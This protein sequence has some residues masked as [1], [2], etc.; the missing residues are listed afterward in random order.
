MRTRGISKA[1][2][3]FFLLSVSVVACVAAVAAQVPSG[4]LQ[5]GNKEFHVYTWG[6]LEEFSKLVDKTT[7]KAG[8]ISRV[9][10]KN[11]IACDT[12][13]GEVNPTN[14]KEPQWSKKWTPIPLNGIQFSGEGHTISGL[15][16]VDTVGLEGGL[17][18]A[19]YGNAV[20]KDLGIVNS[21][22]AGGSYAGAI[23]GGLS[24]NARI[25]NC[26]VNKTI[27]KASGFVG[28]IVGR[29]YGSGMIGCIYSAASVRGM[30]DDTK[31]GGL[32]GWIFDQAVIEDCFWQNTG[33]ESLPQIEFG[34]FT[35]SAFKISNCAGKTANAMRGYDL[36]WKLNEK[37]D[38][39]DYLWICSDT[40]DYP[41]LGD[42]T[43]LLLRKAVDALDIPE[44]VLYTGVAITD[45]KFV[46]ETK[47][48]G[49]LKKEDYSISYQDNTEAGQAALSVKFESRSYLEAGTRIR[50]FTI[51]DLP[52]GEVLQKVKVP[53]DGKQKFARDFVDKAVVLPAR[54]EKVNIT[55]LGVSEPVTNVGDYSARVK[56]SGWGWSM[57]T[58]F[59]YAIE[60]GD[61]SQK[62]FVC[63]LP[64]GNPS[65]FFDGA[66]KTAS[67][68][69]QEG[70]V[71]AGTF[72]VKYN[73][74]DDLPVV[75]GNYVVS[76]AYTEGENYKAGNCVLGNFEIVKSTLPL[77]FKEDGLDYELPSDGIAYFNGLPQEIHVSFKPSVT[78]G[79]KG[80]SL[81]VLYDYAGNK[82]T[83]PPTGV[84]G[85]YLVFVTV[86][87]TGNHSETS[88]PLG[89]F[90]IKKGRHDVSLLQSFIP[91]GQMLAYNYDGTQKG[92]FSLRG[93]GL[94]PG[95]GEMTPMFVEKTSK[96]TLYE[97]P[98]AVGVY[99]LF[100]SF[101]EGMN[102]D[103]GIV[104]GGEFEIKKRE[105]TLEM[106]EINQYTIVPYDGEPHEVSVVLKG[107]YTS[108]GMGEIVVKYEGSEI[109][110]YDYGTY[111]VTISVKEGA[112]YTAVPTLAFVTLEIVN[113]DPTSL[114]KWLYYD[115]TD[116]EYTGN[117]QKIGVQW[118]EGVGRIKIGE[119]KDTLYNNKKEIPQEVGTYKVSVKIAAGA[120]HPEV[121][122]D[123]GSFSI[124]RT[125]P[126][127]FLTYPTSVAWDG[128][129]KEVKVS[130]KD[131]LEGLG[132]PVTVTYE[133]GLVPQNIGDYVV[134]VSIPEGRNFLAAEFQIA[135]SIT[136]KQGT[137]ELLQNDVTYT[138]MQIEKPKIQATT[139]TAQAQAKVKYEYKESDQPD[140]RYNDE[141]PIDAGTYI[142]RA[143]GPAEGDYSEIITEKA[144]KIFQAQGIVEFTLEK[145][146][147]VVGE[148]PVVQLVYTTNEKSMS[149]I[150]YREL[151]DVGIGTEEPPSK[152][153]HYL[154]SLTY[155]PTRNFTLAVSE[156]SFTV[157]GPA[158]NI[159]YT[160]APNTPAGGY[161]VSVG[162]I[163]IN[164]ISNEHTLKYS[165]NAENVAT[166]DETTGLITLHGTGSVTITISQEDNPLYEPATPV[167]LALTIKGSDGIADVLDTPGRVY[168]S[169]G[170]LVPG[171]LIY[172]EA[173]LNESLL[174][175]AEV[176][177]YDLSGKMIEKKRVESRTTSLHTP[178]KTGVYLYAFINTSRG[179]R[180]TIKVV[181]R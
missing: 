89:S 49:L 105:T 137:L 143:I 126:Q 43:K 149:V 116:R 14:G 162:T 124:R 57:D 171:S 62:A 128:L 2:K 70:I 125:N 26:F 157:R 150:R 156:K 85:P 86:P 15:F 98:K 181:V 123:L 37:K 65:V 76:V 60:K 34:E 29:C 166:V 95:I 33:Y 165:S 38:V 131:G 1:H 87:E 100:A 106:F 12:N 90:V 4:G 81:T 64:A 103:K 72:V 139:L 63:T 161:S 132:S 6:Q 129:P 174:R 40:M 141:Q 140:Y 52:I 155:L 23:A 71:G 83:T 177:V 69:Y 172:L 46:I 59:Y 99:K 88:I 11:N 9:V 168:L 170:R 68:N 32:V 48:T 20:I 50:N 146:P 56:V 17:F 7:G 179:F 114:K 18:S 104:E 82:T 111:E 151:A 101:S 109:P 79:F 92:T 133:N 121:E 122:I 117:E 145:N 44:S 142:V 73:G 108:E 110:P 97:A 13:E 28:G 178:T 127:K 27:V 58:T 96:D 169:S 93:S 102:Y 113:V 130:L 134:H 107:G 152:P 75:A 53:Y 54:F 42:T 5:P 8:S 51:E 74:K 39:L 144:F 21:Y 159:T 80:V 3:R 66:P 175:G 19:V 35:G 120:V 94:P 22:I 10:L 167:L 30:K 176:A 147:V 119:I 36:M 148:N 164:A 25:Q 47:E 138:G 84:G 45:P 158:Q 118:A 24:G 135:F 136:P 91:K 173:D 67:V 31:T 41:S 55:V 77:S 115:L 61:L 160:L 16:V 180:R 154:V 153:G 112:G 163:Q 78:D